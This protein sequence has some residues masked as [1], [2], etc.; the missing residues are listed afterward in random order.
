M[1]KLLLI[2]VLAI[3]ILIKGA[4]APLG[5]LSGW[6]LLICRLW[7]MTQGPD[8]PLKALHFYTLKFII[9]LKD[10]KTR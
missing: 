4:L 6:G 2:V 10:F 8:R 5:A 3:G 9:Y 7:G 1:A